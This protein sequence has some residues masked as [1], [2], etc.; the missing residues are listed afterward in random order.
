MSSEAK[1]SSRP[2]RVKGLFMFFLKKMCKKFAEDGVPFTEYFRIASEGWKKLN[3]EELD[4]Y[5][6]EKEQAEKAY[7]YVKC[8]DYHGHKDMNRIR[9]YILR[10][11]KYSWEY[12]GYLLFIEEMFDKCDM[13]LSAQENAVMFAE[14]WRKLSERDRNK[15]RQTALIKRRKDGN[16]RKVLNH[17]DVNSL[18]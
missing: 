1:D 15:Y 4:A 14:M 2:K 13:S 8:E 7:E 17:T 9:K 3:E 12:S 18:F 11:R 16:V 6:R 10:K 5:A